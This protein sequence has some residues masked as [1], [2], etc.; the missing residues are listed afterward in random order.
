MTCPELTTEG[1]N[2][3]LNSASWFL[4]LKFFHS[5]QGPNVDTNLII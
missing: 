4:I 3:S 5:S 2:Q 1:C